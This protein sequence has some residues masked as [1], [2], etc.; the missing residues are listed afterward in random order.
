MIYPPAA[1]RQH[2]RMMRM[3]SG[4]TMLLQ[5]TVR[6]PVLEAAIMKTAWVRSV[7]RMFFG[8]MMAR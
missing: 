1:V 4:T 7:S 5:F 3:D 6:K 8:R 2:V